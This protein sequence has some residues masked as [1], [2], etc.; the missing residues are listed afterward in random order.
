MEAVNSPEEEVVTM[1]KDELVDRLIATGVNGVSS[2]YGHE[3][4]EIY[5]GFLALPMKEVAS[6]WPFLNERVQIA[7]LKEHHEVFMTW[8][9][10]LANE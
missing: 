10:G 3:D 9:N 8:I 2:S 6:L 7:L 4:K 5:T 1:S